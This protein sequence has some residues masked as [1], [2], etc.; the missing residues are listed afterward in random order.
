MKKKVKTNAPV[1]TVEKK[2]SAGKKDLPQKNNNGKPAAP[3]KK[4]PKGEKAF[5]DKTE[6]ELRDELLKAKEERLHKEVEE[7]VVEEKKPD[8]KFQ[9]FLK[10]I[11]Y[12]WE[13]YKWL[14]IIP[15]II[16]LI[17]VIM[18][19]TYIN[20][21]RPLLMRVALV[22]TSDVID[23]LAS[24]QVDYP[25][26][27]GVDAG[28]LPVKVEYDLEFPEETELATDVDDQT[29]AKMQKLNAMVSTG[30][31]DVLIAPEWVIDAYSI[32]GS[33]MNLEDIFDEEFLEEYS[34]I[35][36]YA[37]DENEEE[38]PVGFKLENCSCLGEFTDDIV[39][40][41]VTF[42]YAENLGEFSYFAPW[43]LEQCE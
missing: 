39:P 16:I 23:P 5:E 7:E 20:E 10:S 12:F 18:V 4:K 34:N 36:Y 11:Q 6:A 22:N 15:C 32:S 26:F 3:K 31:L 27:R 24:F 17:T 9:K 37:L 43:V 25:E 8:T 41:M 30:K 35:I 2:V 13:Y 42:D 33:T 29:V 19:V 21:N 40:V 1:E 14:V 38:I 28:E